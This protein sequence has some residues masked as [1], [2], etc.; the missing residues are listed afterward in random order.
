MRR[1]R[2]PIRPGADNG[3][4]SRGNHLS[5]II[6]LPGR[7]VLSYNYF[8]LAKAWGFATSPARMIRPPIE[9]PS[10]ASPRVTALK[11]T[12]L[13]ASTN[14]WLSPARI[15]GTLSDL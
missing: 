10:L 1:K 5:G 6:R 7:L 9:R 8:R 12:I 14:N 13:L 4:F 11:P 15:A 3:N 2:Q